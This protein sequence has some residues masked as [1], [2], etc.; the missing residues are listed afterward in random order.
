MHQ[1]SIYVLQ[2]CQLFQILLNT[3]FLRVGISRNIV[4]ITVILVVHSGI[5]S[6]LLFCHLM[7]FLLCCMLIS[8]QTSASILILCVFSEAQSSETLLVDG[9]KY[10]VV[11]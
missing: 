3:L 2:F 8:T 10:A 9:E 5:F 7:L 6:R 4:F 1:Y 11:G